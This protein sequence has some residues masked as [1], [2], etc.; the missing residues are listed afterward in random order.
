MWY[1]TKNSQSTVEIAHFGL[2]RLVTRPLILVKATLNNEVYVFGG[3][4][5]KQLG[6]ET[7]KPNFK[8]VNE[9]SLSRS[10][11]MFTTV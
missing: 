4:Y 2:D 5:A 11:F 9:F 7:D 8:Q 1:P 10:C 6:S 3:Y